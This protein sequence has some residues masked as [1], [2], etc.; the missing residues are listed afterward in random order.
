MAYTFVNLTNPETQKNVQNAILERIRA[1][2][3]NIREVLTS[4]TTY[5]FTKAMVDIA[6]KIFQISEQRNFK[7]VELGQA[8]IGKQIRYCRQTVNLVLQYLEKIG[9]IKIHRRELGFTHQY[10]FCIPA[11]LEYFVRLI[12]KFNRKKYIKDRGVS[13]S[14]TQSNL[15]LTSYKNYT[16][17]KDSKDERLRIFNKSSPE[18]NR[19]AA[20]SYYIRPPSV[21]FIPKDYKIAPKEMAL[22][23]LGVLKSLL[24]AR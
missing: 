19:F 24:G 10:Q 15:D 18:K 9:L 7:A 13:G 14:V 5:H 21:R 23:C 22:E 11:W 2:R 6:E 17:F 16:E 8:W 1:R 20:D 3:F 4:Q 12:P